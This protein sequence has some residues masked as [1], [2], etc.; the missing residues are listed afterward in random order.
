MTTRTPSN[1]CLGAN[2]TMIVVTSP[3]TTSAAKRFRR[4]GVCDTD[5]AA[6]Q[7]LYLCNLPHPA[8]VPMQPAAV[9]DAG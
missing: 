6:L 3:T 4:G 2:N 1:P 5:P 9:N 8:T 7:L